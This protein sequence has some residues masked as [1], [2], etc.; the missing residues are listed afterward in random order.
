MKSGFGITGR[1]YLVTSF[2][3]L[4]LFGL[5]VLSWN[6][7]D[8]VRGLAEHTKAVSAAQLQRIADIELN[9]TRVSLQLRHA[10]LVRTPAEV[11]ATLGDIGDKRKAIG[12]L[13][14][15]F[16][17]A[18]DTP[19]EKAGFA[20]VPS[21]SADFWTSGVE[22]IRLI[23]AGQ[24]E[25]AFTFLVD[26]TI[27]ARNRLLDAL[28]AEKSRVSK[29]LAADLHGI[30]SDA[31]T[32]RN[33]VVAAVLVSMLALLMLVLSTSRVLMRRIAQAEGVAQR[34]RDGD[35]A[36]AVRDDAVDEFS[37]LMSAL[38][39]M[40]SSLI[41]VVGTV[42][43]NAT[44]VATASAEISQGNND[45]SARTEQQASALEQTASSMEELGST[46]RHNAENAR[47]ASQLAMQASSVA[48]AGG[49]VVSQVVDTMKGINDSSRKIADIIGVIDGIAF[50]TNILALNAAVE[51]AR[52]GEQG[53]GFAVVAS[54]VRSL[55]QRSAE[56]AKEIKSLI[57]ASVERV[58][59]GT[60]LVDKAG[61]TMSE[62]V[63]AIKRVT[64]IVGEI[65]SASQEQ[66]MGVQQVG[67]AVMQMDQT[68]QQNAAL[69][70]QSAAAAD[71]LK[72][73]ALIL[74]EAVS[75]FQLPGG[76]AAPAPVMRQLSPAPQRKMAPPLRAP[77]PKVAFKAA[78]AA[79][80][81]AP[82]LPAALPAQAPR[83][84]QPPA[85]TPPRA[86]VRKP[87]AADNDDWESF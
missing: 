67:Q 50:Q 44:S 54:E 32:M 68:T 61:A 58:G 69:V 25:D 80:P 29:E 7:A 36:S 34:V 11:A 23:E 75:V 79:Q 12:V 21:A 51:A 87:A 72:S 30:E 42:R 74:V 59:H 15:D 13:L 52:A 62:V 47:Q 45:L 19:A 70:E 18:L 10:L 86:N 2:M 37:P 71:S 63:T 27:P 1:L 46:V 24:K 73:Q 35:L 41:R 22:N 9:V 66:S 82:R 49:D 31:V 81:V 53:R 16:E 4:A 78:G 55:A 17:K 38:G 3:A 8:G 14:A 39:D 28:G 60:L 6:K 64:D 33:Q 84:P 57:N 48:V 43:G 76:R 26:K 65:S 83:A 77:A 56:A 85:L 5:A 20:R 40:Q